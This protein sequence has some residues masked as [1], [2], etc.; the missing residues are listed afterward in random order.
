MNTPANSD[1]INVC[2]IPPAE[3]GQ[4]CIELSEGVRSQDTMFTLDGTTKFAHMTL[5]MA[6]LTRER[7]E[8][9]LESVEA[10]LRDQESFECEHTDYFRRPRRN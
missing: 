8:E 6:R 9:V 1:I 10:V 7:L 4:R 5:F 2:I 3:I